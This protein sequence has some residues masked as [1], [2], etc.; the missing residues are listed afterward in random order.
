M[1]SMTLGDKLNEHRRPFPLEVPHGWV[2]D[3]AGELVE[4]TPP[5]ADSGP[6]V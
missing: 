1:K 4:L 2:T 6:H 3:E 5:W